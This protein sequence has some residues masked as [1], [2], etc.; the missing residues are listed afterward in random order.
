MALHRF[1]NVSRHVR[2]RVD[3][4]NIMTPG[5][6]G[7]VV[8]VSVWNVAQVKCHSHCGK[9]EESLNRILERLNPPV[10][11]D[12]GDFSGQP[13]TTICHCEA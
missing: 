3:L 11:L 4:L 2:A 1:C 12:G 13:L 6:T 10:S 7:F 5:E 8:D 9:E